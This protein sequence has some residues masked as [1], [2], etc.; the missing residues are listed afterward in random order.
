M[1]RKG[2]FFFS[3]LYF[4]TTRAPKGFAYLPPLPISRFLLSFPIAHTPLYFVTE[5]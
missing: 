2:H 5:K 4:A 3:L 1:L